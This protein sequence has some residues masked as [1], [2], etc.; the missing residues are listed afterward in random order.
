MKALQRIRL[1]AP[2]LALVII[3]PG[4]AQVKRP[5]T[6]V[7]MLEIPQLTDP[8]LSPNGKQLLFSFSKA[9]WKANTRTSHI[10]RIEADGSG[11]VQL[12]SGI[13][14]ETSARWS[15][16]G[17]RIAFLAR[18]PAEEASAEEANQIYLISNSGGEA[19]QLSRH[20]TAV[21]NIAWS[22]DG[23]VIYFLASDP[24]SADEQAREKAKDDVFAY[25]ENFEQ[26][27]LWKVSVDTK[28]ET[29]LTTGE[30]SV[31]G[32]RVSRDGAK[33]AFQ[34]GPSPLFGD[35]ERAKSG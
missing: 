20:A 1:L 32:Y 33:I 10:W 13:K 28:V 16:D 18:R 31:L 26:Q 12:T 21:S 9:D 24:K 25:D 23:K 22:P 29:R 11:L 35:A 30:T 5:M 27:H 15:P 14:G 19:R 8:Q 4:M 2:I 34:R 6:L 3:S 7:D 17:N